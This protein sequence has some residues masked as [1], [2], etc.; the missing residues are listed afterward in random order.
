MRLASTVVGFVVAVAPASAQHR[1]VG[2]SGH[3]GFASRSVA[4]RSGFGNILYPGTGGPPPV[5]QATFGQRLGATIHGHWASMPPGGVGERPPRHR[6]AGFAGYPVPVFYGGWYGGWSGYEQPPQQLYVTVEQA[7]PPQ[8]PVIINQYYSVPEAKPVV[9]DYSGE[10]LPEP[11]GMRSFHAPVGGRAA[12]VLNAEDEP[13]QPPTI[14]LIAYRDQAI[15]PAV[16]YWLEGDT[17]HYVTVQGSH[18]QASLDLI[19]EEF[20]RRLNEERGVEFAI[21]KR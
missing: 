15:Y 10:K 11:S 3:S 4:A 7:P 18:N 8:P 19:D 2:V 12:A 9:R 6:A 17:L 1:G 20:S 21:E 13:D 14:Y 5:G 16:G